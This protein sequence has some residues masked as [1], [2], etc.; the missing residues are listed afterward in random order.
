MELVKIETEVTKEVHEIGLAVKKVIESYK[1]ATADGW[2]PG[3]DI[4][5]ILMGSYQGLLTAIDGVE[6][7]GSE[8]K[9]EPVKAAMGALIPLSEGVE[10]LME[11]KEDES[12]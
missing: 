11:K 4:P 6:K 12:K 7:S 8:F 10:L 1:Q 9:T 2:Q 5:Q 3:T